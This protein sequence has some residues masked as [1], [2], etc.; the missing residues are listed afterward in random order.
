MNEQQI[1]ATLDQIEEELSDGEATAELLND[2]GVGYYL[3]GELSQ[4]RDYLETAAGMEETPSI[5]FNLGN[6]YSELNQPELAIDT[7]LRVLDAD[8]NHVGA[9]NNLADEYEALGEPEKAHELFHY[10]T[11][12]QPDEAI[13]H[14]NLG[15]FFLRQNQHIEAAK[16]YEAALKADKTFVD[17]YHNIAWI[18]YKSA[19]YSDS[20]RYIEKGLEIENNH[21][22]L[23]ELKQSVMDAQ[24]ET[25]G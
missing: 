8:P 14:F 6:T 4:S 11:N 22:D 1:R 23:T 19:A 9:L 16:C 10:L 17:A 5:L 18:L 25:A 13:S 21:N 24:D 3:L 12:L 2:A 15:N 20:M 7:F